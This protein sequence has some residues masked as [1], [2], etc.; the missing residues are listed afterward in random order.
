MTKPTL[1]LLILILIMSALTLISCKSTEEATAAE[2]KAEEQ[3]HQS[4]FDAHVNIQGP[5]SQQELINNY[6]IFAV[7]RQDKASAQVINQINMIE[8]ETQIRAF[9]GTWCHDSQREIPYLLQ[10]MQSVDNPNVT[11]DLIALNLK[12]QESTGQAQA[13][14]IKYT[15]TIVVYQNNTEVGR[16]VEKTSMPIGEEILAIIQE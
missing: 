11:F 10:L 9:F 13:A 7:K 3:P 6:P 16:I 5:I 12:K 14:Q 1:T 2:A 8:Q 4:R 15:P